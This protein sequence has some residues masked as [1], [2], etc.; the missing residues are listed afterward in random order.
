M[1]QTLFLLAA[2]ARG[3]APAG[4]KPAAPY[5]EPATGLVFPA[6]LG[7]LDRGEAHRFEQAGLG[8]G[9][10]YS[11][12]TVKADVYVYDLGEKELGTGGD[13][14]AVRRHFQRAQKD[15]AAAAEQGYYRGVR[16][17]VEDQALLETGAGKLAMQHARFEYVETGKAGGG[18]ERDRVSHLLVTAYKD[19]FL[20]VRFTFDASEKE[21]GEEA[22]KA[23]LADLG[24]IVK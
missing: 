9:I 12:K 3:D 11:G 22:L 10:R 15:I 23:F 2:L 24:R 6:A 1:L 4:E 19:N 16:R 8:V 13:S 7:P 21:S 20:K 18:A 5:V 17:T 14:D